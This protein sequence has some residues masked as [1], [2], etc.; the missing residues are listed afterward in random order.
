MNALQQIIKRQS[1][2]NGNYEF[3]VEHKLRRLHLQQSG[4]NFREVTFEWLARLRLQLDRLAVAERKT[5]KAVPLGL[6][7]P[8]VAGGYLA[9]QQRFH[10][11]KGWFDWQGHDAGNIT[12]PMSN[13]QSLKSA[14]RKST[15]LNSSH[16]DI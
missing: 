1:I 5:A 2:L 11:G 16:T 8:V 3:A 13:V 4:D 15:R 12:S 6:V 9:H 14:D 7:L 10:R